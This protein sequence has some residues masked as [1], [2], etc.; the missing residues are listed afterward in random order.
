MTVLTQPLEQESLARSHFDP[1]S[2]VTAASKG[3]CFDHK[4]MVFFASDARANEYDRNVS[5]GSEGRDPFC[6]KLQEFPA[7]CGKEQLAELIDPKL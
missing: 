4:E 5:L 2:L 7:L 1:F 3:F 6:H